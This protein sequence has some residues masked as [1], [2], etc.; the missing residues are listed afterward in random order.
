MKEILKS[1]EKENI[2][3][4]KKNFTLLKGDSIE[5]MK[6][7]KEKSIDMIF[8]DPPYFLSNDGITLSLIHI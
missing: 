1:I 8:A 6:K 2:Y 4:N 7:L 5:L 3:Y